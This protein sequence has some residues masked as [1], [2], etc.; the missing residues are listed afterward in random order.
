[1]NLPVANSDFGEQVC[2]AAGSCL[3][4][5]AFAPGEEEDS[6]SEDLQP[7]KRTQRASVESTQMNC[8]MTRAKR[9]PA[10]GV[11]VAGSNPCVHREVC[12]VLGA[13]GC[14]VSDRQV[15]PLKPTPT[16]SRAMKCRTLHNVVP[17][18][19]SVFSVRRRTKK[20]CFTGHSL[21]MELL[22]C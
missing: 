1:M 12:W 13:V 3:T 14:R 18:A 7:Q 11:A 21:Q 22:Q 10:G 16:S 6:E 8:C 2:F 20:G 17:R 15:V 5:P 9:H 4:S 19:G